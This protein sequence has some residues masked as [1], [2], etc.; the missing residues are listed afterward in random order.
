MADDLVLDGYSD[1]F[2]P[3]RDELTLAF[4]NLAAQGL[5]GF[6]SA[7]YWASTESEPTRAWTNSFWSGFVY[8]NAFWRKSSS[9]RF[10]PVRAF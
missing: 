3:S 5:G 6:A 9:A 2:L 4:N 10:R 8:T 1:W 7:E